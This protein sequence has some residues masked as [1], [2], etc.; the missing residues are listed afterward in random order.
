MKVKLEGKGQEYIVKQLFGNNEIDERIVASGEE[1]TIS[2]SK[3]N[4]L[5]IL[6]GSLIPTE[7]VLH[8]NY[9]NPFNPV[10][11]IKYGIPKAERVELTIFNVLGERIANLV[12]EEQE[13]GYYTV[14]WDGSNIS[15]GVY[16]YTLK[17]GDNYSVKKMILLR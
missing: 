5:R 12:N 11:Q 16:L 6:N 15:S 4:K 13:A 14:K 7:F 10:T 1:I 3:V 17:V 8:Q 2:N 9:P